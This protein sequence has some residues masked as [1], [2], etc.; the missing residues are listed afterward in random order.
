MNLLTVEEKAAMTGPYLVQAG[1]SKDKLPEVIRAAS[2]RIKIAGDILDYA[3]FFV[4]GSQMVYDESA[5][6]KRIRSPEEAPGLLRRFTDV[7]LELKAFDAASIE[8][9]LQRFVDFEGIRHAQIVHALR[10]AVTGKTVGFGLFEGL[11][12]LGK[13]ES[14]AR[15]GLALARLESR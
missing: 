3:N 8:Q 12:V 13:A 1:L 6:D 15:I 5:F 11:E 14:V 9:S 2:D 4:P 10:V 7:L